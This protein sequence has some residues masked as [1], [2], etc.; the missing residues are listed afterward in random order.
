ML[1]LRFR[2]EEPTLGIFTL[3]NGQRV[4]MTLPYGAV[5]TKAS[6]TTGDVMI[7]VW[8]E[9]RKVRMFEQDLLERGL[10]MG[11]GA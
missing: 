1:T 2:L 6:A 11:A 9:E 8:W 5:V 10:A 7:D 3:E 4:A